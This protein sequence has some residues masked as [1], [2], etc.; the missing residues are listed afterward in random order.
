MSSRKDTDRGVRCLSRR[1]VDLAVAGDD[2]VDGGARDST[3]LNVVGDWLATDAPGDSMAYSS[4]L[5][6]DRAMARSA[7]ARP[8]AGKRG[9]VP[10]WSSF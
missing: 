7:R 3:V 4:S 9:I 1:P 6:S 10:L 2:A 5:E 8:W